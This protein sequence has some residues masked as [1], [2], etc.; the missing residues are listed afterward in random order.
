M[1]IYKGGYPAYGQSIG[2]LMLDTQFPRMPGEIG[3]A[4]SFPFPVIHKVV[5][6]A[7]PRRVVLEGD[8]ALLEPFVSAARE[9]EEMGVRAIT[10][11]CGFM[12]LF[13]RQMA[14]RL[15]VPFLSSSLILVPMV[16]RMV[17]GRPVGILTA[18]RSALTERHF[19]GVGW[20]SK[21]FPVV[22]QG[23]QEDSLFSRAHYENRPAIDFDQ[24][25]QEVVEA[26]RRMV[27]EHPEVAAIVMECTNLPPYASNVQQMVDRPVF[28]IVTLVKMVYAAL[29]RREFRK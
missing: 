15:R 11:S 1:T 4:A 26:A 9:L 23:L 19:A 25:R 17:G 22:I 14:E 20:S 7:S 28:S 29:E 27:E 21:D 6:D 3:N 2:I 12:A 16:S 10:T 13:H 5:R 24:I 18:S 8:P